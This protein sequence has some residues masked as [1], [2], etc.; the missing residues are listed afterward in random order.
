MDIG[1]YQ[2]M[3]KQLIGKSANFVCGE[4]IYINLTPFFRSNS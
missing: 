1:L 4:L 2:N 3:Y